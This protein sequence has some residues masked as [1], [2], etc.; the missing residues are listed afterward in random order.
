[1]RDD[2]VIVL[3]GDQTGQE[4]LEESLRV[5]APDVIGIELDFPRFDLSLET[6]RATRN[7]V[8]Y[9]A[10]ATCMP[11]LASNSGFHDLLPPELRFPRHDHR[12]LAEK[13]VRLKEADRAEIGRGLRAVVEERHSVGHWAD[14]VARVVA[15]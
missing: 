9:E 2:T 13:L 14:E 11:V 3:E 7:E 1:M 8:V 4:L 15:R 10:A 5:L 12:E 6:R